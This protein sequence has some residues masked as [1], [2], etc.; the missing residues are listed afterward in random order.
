MLPRNLSINIWAGC[1]CDSVSPPWGRPWICKG[2]EKDGFVLLS[3]RGIH[4]VDGSK[5]RRSPVDMV[6]YISHYLQGFFITSKRWLALGFLNHQQY[7]L[8]WKSPSI[9]TTCQ[10]V[11]WDF[12][13]QQAWRIHH[14]FLGICSPLT[15]TQPSELKHVPS[16]LL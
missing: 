5:I 6:V 1:Y 10:L 9:S 11:V 2:C 4:T 12:F 15:W 7:H 13:H 16:L 14:H 3:Y 8:G